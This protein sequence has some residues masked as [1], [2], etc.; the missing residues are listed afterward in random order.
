MTKGG[1]SKIEFI[2]EGFRQIVNSNECQE[3]VR[4]ITEGIASKA[5]ANAG[6]DS[7]QAQTVQARTRW[8]GLVSS[9][10]AESYQA[11]A[12]DKALTGAIK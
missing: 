6:L 12:E 3:L 7:F 10:D 4:D 1:I 9:T 11:E 8:I 5:N 2:S